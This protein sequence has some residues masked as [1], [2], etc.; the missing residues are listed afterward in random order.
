MNTVRGYIQSLPY[1]VGLTDTELDVIIQ[2]S[3]LYRFAAGETIFWEGDDSRGLWVIEQGTVKI[4]KTRPDGGEYIL[5]L[6]GVGDT[7]NDMAARGGG[8]T[9][10]SAA[11]LSPD[12]MVWVIPQATIQTIL[13]QNSQVALN[14]IS[15]LTR[16]V[17][18]L[19]SQME[20]L[21]MHS[22]GVRLARFLLHQS[23]SESPHPTGVTRTAIA[24]HLNTTPQTVSVVLREFE[25][26]GAIAFDRQRIHILQPA[27]LRR[28]ALLT[29]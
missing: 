7:F 21:A 4:Y 10:A 6:L 29:P 19:V 1:L 13:T 18:G 22:V 16:R 8:T 9:P 20:D 27:I 28:L 5:H 2:H 25:T 3:R 12:L 23:E 26:A 17:R 11:A 24:A 15:L 14:A